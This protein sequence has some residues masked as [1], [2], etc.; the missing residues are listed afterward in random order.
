M[1][2]LK[3]SY[4]S[5]F[6]GPVVEEHDT[7]MHFTDGV[8]RGIYPQKILRCGPVNATFFEN[9]LHDQQF[10]TVQDLYNHCVNIMRGHN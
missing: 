8:E 6:G 3:F 1:I 9:S 5:P 4:T 7:L 10:A 2:D